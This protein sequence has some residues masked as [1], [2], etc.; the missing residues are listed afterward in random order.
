MSKGHNKKRNVGVVYEQLV[1]T[2]S[3]NLVEGNKEASNKALRIIRKYFVPGTELYKEFRLF[4]ALTQTYAKSDALASRILE[5]TKHAVVQHNTESLRREKSNLINEINRSFDKNTFYNTPVKNYKLFATIHTLIEEWRSEYPDVMRRAQY[6]SNL[7]EWLMTPK[8][9]VIVEKLKT[10]NI[11][12]LTVRIMR[13]SFNK[14]FGDTLNE[15]QR[16]LLQ[17][18]AFAGDQKKVQKLMGEQKT[19]ALKSLYRYQTQCE[20][21]IVEQKIPSAIKILETLDTNDTSD[22]NIAK[23]MT[24][25][26][27]CDEL[28]ENNNG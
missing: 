24:V 6:E 19:I 25:S 3:K 13:E 2:V 28:L 10:P 20:S 27:L 12:D 4:N 23:F 11:N 14:K 21:K 1:T 15:N 16:D 9:E 8:E 17:T 7:H 18:I 22:S 26:R 5:D